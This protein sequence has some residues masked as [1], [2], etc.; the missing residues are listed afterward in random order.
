MKESFI[1]AI[2]TMV[3]TVFND[4]IDFT[5]FFGITTFKKGEFPF[6]FV[7]FFNGLI[8]RCGLIV[9]VFSYRY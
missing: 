3:A 7:W 1:T 8:S 4:I 6:G 2:T 9:L 5:C